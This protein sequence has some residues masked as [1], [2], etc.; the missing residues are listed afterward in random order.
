MSRF[1]TGILCANLAEMQYWRGFQRM[2]VG[3]KFF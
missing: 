3:L 2:V 1:S